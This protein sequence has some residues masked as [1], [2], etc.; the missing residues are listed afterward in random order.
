MAEDELDDFFEGLKNVE[1]EKDESEWEEERAKSPPK[2]R[3]RTRNERKKK[4]EKKQKRRKISTKSKILPL[5]GQERRLTEEEYQIIF[6]PEEYAALEGKTEFERELA[7]TE[8]V[9]KENERRRLHNLRAEATMS[10]GEGEGGESFHFDDEEEGDEDDDEDDD[11]DSYAEEDQWDDEDAGAGGTVSH[12]DLNRIR[13]ETKDEIGLQSVERGDRRMAPEDTTE[14]LILLEDLHKLSLTRDELIFLLEH[15]RLSDHET[16]G[17]Y[18]RWPVERW[19]Y[20]QPQQIY[21]IGRIVGIERGEPYSLH[22]RGTTTDIYILAKGPRGTG[23]NDTTR[24]KIFEVSSKSATSNEYMDI[25]RSD[26]YFQSEFKVSKSKVGSKYHLKKM[27]L[28]ISNG[29]DGGM[30]GL[31]RTEHFGNASLAVTKLRNMLHH[32]KTL[33]HPAPERIQLLTRQLAA[34]EKIAE[35]EK[36]LYYR[37]KKNEMDAKRTA[38]QASLKTERRHKQSTIMHQK[39]AMESPAKKDS[40]QSRYVDDP[41]TRLRKEHDV[42]LDIDLS[43]LPFQQD[44]IVRKLV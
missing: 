4:Q 27:Y 8:A 1:P 23:G 43:L 32:E 17:F 6:T 44:T 39:R 41:W 20:G 3:R 38:V 24:L 25:L 40:T 34:A 35:K 18:V 31:L 15:D 16:N 21:R 5:I 2:T 42:S 13:Q 12:T 22:Q 37:R 29:A 28:R 7:L 9:E 30:Q 10:E 33:V 19:F 36:E 11:D 26:D 14:S